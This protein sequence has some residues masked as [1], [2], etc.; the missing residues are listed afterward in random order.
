MN[1][2]YDLNAPRQYVAVVHLYR[3]LPRLAEQIERPGNL[4]EFDWLPHS[5]EVLTIDG[6]SRWDLEREAQHVAH[7]QLEQAY[8]PDDRDAGAR[9]WWAARPGPD[10]TQSMFVEWRDSMPLIVW[11][12]DVVQVSTYKKET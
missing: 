6:L 3:P 4:V 5:V 8:D 11:T 10:A 7:M 9:A 1:I 2:T 12:V